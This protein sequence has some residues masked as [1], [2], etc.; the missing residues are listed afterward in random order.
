MRNQPVFFG[1]LME[2]EGNRGVTG[3]GAEG[4]VMLA[5]ALV[6]TLVAALVA[7]EIVHARL[8]PAHE[9]ARVALGS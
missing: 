1:L 6:I 3:L 5:G 4:G 8:T 9:R 2:P 7:F